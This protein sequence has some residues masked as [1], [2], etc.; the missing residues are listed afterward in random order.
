MTLLWISL[1]AAGVLGLAALIYWQ[2]VIAEGTYLG[3][4]AVAVMYDWVSRRYDA[5]KQ[6]APQDEKWFVAGPLH[7]GLAGMLRPVLLDVATGT[8]RV[9]LAL[10]CNRFAGQHFDGQIIGLDLSR[11]MLRQARS[12]LQLY[13]DQVTLVWQDASRLPFDDQVFDAVTCLESLEF[14][15][16]PLEALS[17]MVRVLAPNG[18]LFLSNRVGREARL[19]PGRA[20]PRDQLAPLLA[21]NGL[22]DVHVRPWQ[23]NYDLATARRAGQ[24]HTERGGAVPAT[25]LLRCPHCSGRLHS[26]GT[27]DEAGSPKGQVLRRGPATLSCGACRR[28]YPIRQGVVWLATD[29]G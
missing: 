9:P 19:L 6:F 21:A 18:M 14:F 10:L 8:G 11:G 28:V 23:V 20:I 12:K 5:V 27:A 15:P 13:G 26:G 29:H 17:E 4:H 1:A 7:V 3:P 24:R 25:E 16:R 22:E 2:L